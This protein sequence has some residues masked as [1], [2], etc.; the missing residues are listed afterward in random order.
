MTERPAQPLTGA[1]ALSALFGRIGDHALV[2]LVARAYPTWEHLVSAPLQDRAWRIG[3]WAAALRLPRECPPLG[4]LGH[5]VSVRSRYEASYPAPLLDLADAP[6]LLYSRG[7]VPARPLLAI[8]GSHYPA[9]DGHSAA[10]AAARAAATAGVPIVAA[11]DSG[12]GHV[13]L[14]ACAEANGVAVAVVSADLATTG[15]NTALLERLLTLGGA[16]ISEWGPGA[17]W[18]ESKV[19]TS[20]RLVAALASVVVLAELGLH[21]T[22]GA[23]LARAAIATGRYLAVPAPNDPDLTP[24]A[25]TGTAVLALGRRFSREAFGTSVRLEHRLNSGKSAADAVVSTP[26]DLHQIVKELRPAATPARSA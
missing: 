1:D 16:A 10:T 6:V 18:A 8:G 13:A 19:L 25:A 20:A 21:P 23:L 26:A 3:P 17:E 5:G 11:L 9:D 2:D 7:V 15:A 22:G 12:C 24:V 4:H 14:E